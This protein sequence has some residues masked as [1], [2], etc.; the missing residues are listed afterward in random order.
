MGEY[1]NRGILLHDSYFVYLG[2]GQYLER[3]EDGMLIIILTPGPGWS[4]SVSVTLVEFI[5]FHF[6]FSES[7]YYIFPVDYN[8]IYNTVIM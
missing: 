3:A 1:L 4:A 6:S 8:T 5:N 7:H 2:G